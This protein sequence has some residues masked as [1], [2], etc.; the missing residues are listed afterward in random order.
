MEEILLLVLIVVLILLISLR[1]KLKS[2]T[3]YIS[4]RLDELHRKIDKISHGETLTKEPEADEK[5]EVAFPS[6]R[7]SRKPP[8]P[9]PEPEPEIEPVPI[10]MPVAAAGPARIEEVPIPAITATP[11]VAATTTSNKPPR[12]SFFERNPDLEKFIGENLA[13]KIGIA[14]LVI[15]IGFFVKYAIDQDW[16]NEIGRVFIGIV[17]GGILLGVAHRMRKTLEA[18]SSVLVGGGIA[19][20]YLTIAIA[21]HEYK[22]FNQATAFVIM[23]GIT[24]FAVLFSIGYNRP[25]LAVLSILGGFASPFMVSTGSGNYVVLFVYILI[26]DVG[27]LVLAYY[28]KWNIVNIVSYV[29]T[30]IL[31]GSWLS[32]Q[33]D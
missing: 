16:I 19:V 1:N 3:T 17:A 33:F 2:E 15:G 7:T 6:T 4:S 8:E 28:K 31:F 18:F 10:P 20:L 29:F 9:E 11:D 23:L 25:E 26:L 12:Q 27:M 13:N 21:F 32:T 14:I 22:L 24:G 30:V 5:I